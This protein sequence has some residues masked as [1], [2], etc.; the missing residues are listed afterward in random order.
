MPPSGTSAGQGFGNIKDPYRPDMLKP[1]IRS[2]FP[3]IDRFVEMM[4]CCG[5]KQDNV[6]RMLEQ[7]ELFSFEDEFKDAN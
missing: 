1:S 2:K 6:T 4:N 5:S 3:W 7:K